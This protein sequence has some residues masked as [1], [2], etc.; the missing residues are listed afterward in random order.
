M[1][2][3]LAYKWAAQATR[4][5]EKLIEPHKIEQLADLISSAILESYKLGIIKGK[6]EKMKNP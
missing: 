4:P 6:N 3:A 2:E 5:I 1:D